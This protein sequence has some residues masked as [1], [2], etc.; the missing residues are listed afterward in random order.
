[1]GVLI[2]SFLILV[3]LAAFVY[4]VLLYKHTRTTFSLDDEEGMREVLKKYKNM[5]D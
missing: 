2:I 3:V 4:R 5:A 1:M